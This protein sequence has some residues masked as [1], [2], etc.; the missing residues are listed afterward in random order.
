VKRLQAVR[1][2]RS[3]DAVERALADLGRAASE[4]DANLMPAL[5]DAVRAYATEG[6]IMNAL[7]DVFGRYVETPRL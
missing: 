3:A 6:E 5:L 1:A 7:A 2:D 4:P